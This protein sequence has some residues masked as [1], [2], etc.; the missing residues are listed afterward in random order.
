M[1]ALMKILS[2]T[3]H[4]NRGKFYPWVVVGLLSVVALLN[5]LDRQILSVMQDA[6]KVDI[7]ELNR[8]EAFGA[9][10]AIFLYV[11]GAVSLSPEVLPTGLTGSG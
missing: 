2:A 7:V 11:Y 4:K 3:D 10:M 9:L 1:S 6:I 5:Y 8:S